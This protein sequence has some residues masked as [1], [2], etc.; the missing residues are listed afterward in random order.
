MFIF[1]KWRLRQALNVFGI[2]RFVLGL[3]MLLVLI[4]LAKSQVLFQAMNGSWQR[5]VKSGHLAKQSW[6]RLARAMCW[7]RRCRL[8][9][10]LVQAFDVMG[11]E[12]TDASAAWQSQHREKAN[13]LS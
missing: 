8:Y 12:R 2:W 4:S 5:M 7:R 9:G 1:M 10:L 11:G 13:I 3:V 6:Q